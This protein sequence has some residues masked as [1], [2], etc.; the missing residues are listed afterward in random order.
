MQVPVLPHHR[1]QKLGVPDVGQRSWSDPREIRRTLRAT[2]VLAAEVGAG[3][4]IS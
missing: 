2:E 4:M 3:P 1:F